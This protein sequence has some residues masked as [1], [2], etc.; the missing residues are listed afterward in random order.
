MVILSVEKKSSYSYCFWNISKLFIYEC[1]FSREIEMKNSRTIKKVC[2]CCKVEKPLCSFSRKD[3]CRK[4]SEEGILLSLEDIFPGSKEKE[5]IPLI[6]K[7]LKFLKQ[8]AVE[9]GII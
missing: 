2:E 1:L 7:D 5:L 4:C 6:I 3:I 9:A 8:K